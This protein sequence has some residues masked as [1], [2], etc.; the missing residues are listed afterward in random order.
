MSLTLATNTKD[1][2]ESESDATELTPMNV[3]VNPKTIRPSGK[4]LAVGK[5]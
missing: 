3:V 2:A 5:G 1:A 4:K